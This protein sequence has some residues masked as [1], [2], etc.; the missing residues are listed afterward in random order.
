MHCE[1]CF[2][3]SAPLCFYLPL[4][5]SPSSLAAAASRLNSQVCFFDSFSH[6]CLL[7]DYADEQSGCL[8]HSRISFIPKSRY[9]WY[10]TPLCPSCPATAFLK[11]RTPFHLRS[12][13]KQWSSSTIVGDQ[14]R[15]GFCWASSPFA[16]VANEDARREGCEVGGVSGH[17]FGPSC[18]FD[19]YFILYLRSV[20]DAYHG[21]GLVLHTARRHRSRKTGGARGLFI[22]FRC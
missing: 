19:L 10:Q 6:C 11:H 5:F 7:Y 14:M 17:S 15:I 8:Q 9:I 20:L 22:Y 4:S 21:W 18:G 2:W 16:A 1:G 13:A 3:F 12:Q